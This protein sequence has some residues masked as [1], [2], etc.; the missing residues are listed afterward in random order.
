MI[1]LI[2]FLQ[3]TPLEASTRQQP[4]TRLAQEVAQSVEWQEVSIVSATV[5][6]QL[7]AINGSDG[8]LPTQKQH[9]QPIENGVSLLTSHLKRAETT[10][11]GT[12]FFLHSGGH[13]DPSRAPVTVKQEYPGIDFFNLLGNTHC[14]PDGQYDRQCNLIGIPGSR[15]FA[16]GMAEMVDPAPG[17]V[18]NHDGYQRA[19]FPFICANLVEMNSGQPLFHPYV[20][21]MVDGVSI[22]FIG[23]LLQSSPSAQPFEGVH[24]LEIRN[25]SESINQYVKILQ[26]QGVHTIVVMIH[27]GGNRTSDGRG[28]NTGA[29]DDALA[30]ILSQLDQEVD[31]VLCNEEQTV[32]NTLAFNKGGREMLVVQTRAEEEGFAKIQLTISRGSNEV[33]AMRSTIRPPWGESDPGIQTEARVAKLNKEIGGLGETVVHDPSPRLS[34]PWAEKPM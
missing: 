33:V 7:L 15:E 20:V 9:G 21:R 6:V 18:S 25:E 3:E 30:P 27:K 17:D 23:A 13:V 14:R 10:W 29:Q 11:P 8:E 22:G 12:T 32:Q 16:Q 24:N 28:K 2:G 26:D 1:A 19:H 31:V 4:T 5:A 34:E